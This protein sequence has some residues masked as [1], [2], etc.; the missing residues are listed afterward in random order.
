MASN[1]D[2]APPPPEEIQ[3][4]MSNKNGTSGK[5]ATSI[6][7]DSARGTP[8]D[9]LPPVEQFDP[10]PAPPSYNDVITQPNG[11]VEKD[12]PAILEVSTTTANGV[13]ADKYKNI[14]M[15]NGNV[16]DGDGKKDGDDDDDGD[17]KDDKAETVQ[18]VSFSQL[19][20][21]ANCTDGFLLMGGVLAAMVHGLAFPLMVIVFGGMTDSLVESGTNNSAGWNVSLP[22]G[23]TYD[24]FVQ[25]EID[26]A[27]NEFLKD[28][29]RYALYFVFIGLGAF[30]AAYFQITC[31]VTTAERQAY[32][33]RT[34]F[35]R[36]ILR[37]EI[38]WFDTNPSGE[39]STRLSDDITKIKSGIGDKLGT[40]VQY[41]TA[42]LGGFVVGF[43]Y[44]WELTLVILAV[45][46]LLAVCA[47]LM[48]K[49][50]TSMTGTELDAYAKAG[51]VAEEVLSAIRT[52]AAFGGEKKEAERYR[53]N[54]HSAKSV[55]IK[56]GVVSGAG[57]GIT[58]LIVFCTYALGFWY[59][60]QLILDPD[61]DY[62]IGSM[63]TVF[64]AVLIG[65]FSLGN[66]GPSIGD[67]AVARGAA[68]KIW[69]I[70]D[71]IPSIDSSSPD[72]EKPPIIGNIEL[73]DV[74]FQYP[75]RPDVKVLQGMNLSVSV[76][77]TVALVGASGCGKSTTVSLIQRFYDV[78]S[79]CVRIDGKDVRDMNLNWLRT[80]VGVVSQEPVLFATTIAENIR[81]GRE[82]VTQAEI[83]K[84][85]KEAN[86]HDF[87]SGLP[88]AYNTMVGQRGAQLSGG[89]K[90]RVAI[91][92]A[93]VRDPKILLLDEATSAL[94]TESEA[95]VQAALD[96]ASE[97]RTTVVIAH[98]LTT[99]RN[100]D[101][102]CAV[103]NGVIMEE[104]NHDVL[105]AQEGLYYQLVMMQTKKKDGDS[106]DEDEADE[107]ELK[108]PLS[109]LKRNESGKRTSHK[110][111][112]RTFSHESKK[113]AAEEEEGEEEKDEIPEVGMSRI[114]KMNRPEWPYILG[115]SLAAVLN[116]AVQ[117]AFAIIFSKI[118]S[119]FALPEDQIEEEAE[120]FC[121]LFVVI[122]VASGIA[123]VL[124]SSFFGKSG[125]E[126]TLRLRHLS[127]TAMLKQEIGWFDDSKNSTGALTTRLATDASLVQGAAGIRIATVIQSIANMGTG[128]II[129]FYFGWEM[130]LVVL[131]CV[132]F[133]A[134]G[135]ALEMKM[136]AGFA[137]ADKEALEGAGKVASEAIDNIRTV[138]SLTKESKFYQLYCDL[139]YP[140]H[141]ASLKKAHIF[142]LTFGFAQCMV[143]LVHAVA[144]R[145]GAW[146]IELNR[147]T[148]EEVFLVFS[149][150]A[151]GAMALGQASAFAPDAAKAKLAANNIFFL[152]DRE[153]EIDSSSP[154]GLKP[155]K[156][157]SVIEFHDVKFRYPTRPDVPVL[158]G[159]NIKVNTGQRVALVGS[160]GCGKST[161]IQLTE[162]FYNT[163]AGHVSLDGKDL[164]DL[165]IQW[166][167]SQIGIVSQE[168]ILFDCTIAENIAYGD[169]SREPSM[170]EII[171]AAKNANIHSFIDSLPLGYETR[172]G[173]KGTQLSGGQ[174]QRVAIA[175]ALLRNPKILLLDE[176][177]S[178]LDT[179]SER[180][181]Q[182]ALDKASEGR[183]CIVIAHRLSTIQDAD[184]IFVIHHG[185]VV[186]EGKHS[187]LI[188]KEGVYYRLNNTQATMK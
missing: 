18:M 102:I 80:H 8:T 166:L 139:L 5:T 140:P 169:N 91:A 145:F 9:G 34:K 51:A 116:G 61:N 110:K 120:L 135:G 26:K 168:P 38:G 70:I 156:C 129:A 7:Y 124:Q 69:D 49:L 90:Q 122:G 150:I 128:I 178:A 89:Q 167:R 127:F 22:N 141:K 170:D 39:L 160:S 136:L 82:D 100:A 179:E 121:I 59:G 30:V 86:C 164:V 119:V 53:D 47:F 75:S 177:T 99:I 25:E 42:F 17:K 67:I 21:F 118:I 96:K 108:R 77:Q 12:S 41:F 103:Q 48:T 154:D 29:N 62:T 143:F 173:D 2:I 40:F 111:L 174:K 180:V 126:L 56:K 95:T 94:D 142:G 15:E 144:F 11:S 73:E 172:V 98:R 101:K 138:A 54:L 36:S 157:D 181:V 63:L 186:E 58:F 32:L 43:I 152:L 27:M 163:L 134:V 20:R 93:L 24:D 4:E 159:F 105:M 155:D 109:S 1:G 133:M 66:A 185:R 57:M 92:R 55:G 182:E 88:D 19:F 13:H 87:I 64:F 72:G 184:R 125:E 113:S 10:L 76:G 107:F 117:P 187:E 115:G 83:E 14:D 85:C 183:T 6:T 147:M 28:M 123:F 33:M 31:F 151:F 81:Y 37:Q 44:G 165:N 45:S 148:F 175:R 60:T 74:H 130:T 171:D 188:A 153:P 112:S 46:P 176:A 23:T 79:G 50:I 146:M 162:R 97:G 106:D 161:A 132:P 84:A 149:C 131:A 71:L 16:P 114:M 104:G 52:V 137:T 3:L 68:R 35:F 158:R 65:A 78:I